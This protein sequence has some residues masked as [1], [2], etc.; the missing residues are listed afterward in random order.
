MKILIS[1][2][3]VSAAFISPAYSQTDENLK[4]FPAAKQGMQRYVITLENK[5]NE[6][7]YKVEVFA[8]KTMKVDCNHHGL[9]GNFET[10]T[11]KGWGYT[12][13]NFQ[14]KGRTTSTL[15]GCPDNTLK[16]AFIASSK[17]LRYNSKLPLVVYVPEGFE[18]RYRIWE[19]QEKEE[20][21]EVK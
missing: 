9:I 13:Y 20:Q 8:G 12:Y 14:S 10:K 16:D 18:V 3:L 21:A 17:A 4:P 1:I 11:V 5:A 2:L 15:M 19:R 7:D 6:S